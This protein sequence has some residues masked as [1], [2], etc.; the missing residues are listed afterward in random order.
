MNPRIEK[1]KEE[2]SKTE[3]KID[4]LSARLKAL[5]EKITQLENADIVGM[6]RE[7]GM[8]PDQLAELLRRSR[9]RSAEPAG[10]TEGTDE[11]K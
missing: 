10:E 8:T 5:D 4:A 2:R 6:V 1:L 3:R 11:R 9:N 7:I